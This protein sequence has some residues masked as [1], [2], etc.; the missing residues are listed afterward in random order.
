MGEVQHG[1]E[2]LG[3]FLLANENAAKA[4]HPVSQPMGLN[5]MACHRYPFVEKRIARNVNHQWIEADML[6]ATDL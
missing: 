6:V 4:V 2:C 5:G 1:D 3:Q